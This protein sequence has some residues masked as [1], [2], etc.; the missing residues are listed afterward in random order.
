M[1]LD[2]GVLFLIGLPLGL[3]CCMLHVGFWLRWRDRALLWWASSNGLGVVGALLMLSY[4]RLP[5]E[6][7]RSVAET[8]LFASGLLL[9]LGFRCLAGQSLPLRAFAAATL[10]YLAGFELLQSFVN[11]LAALIMLASFGHG[12]L[13]A[14]VAFD[15]G[16]SQL[17]DRLRVRTALVVVFALHALFY[18]FRSVTAVTVEAGADFLHTVGLQSATLLIGLINVVLWNA[19]AL[20]MAGERHRAPAAPQAK[21]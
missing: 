19:G 3:V 18:L 10:I 5:S 1:K 4:V 6:T 9:W 7:V 2:V 16:R 20:W 11:D 13:H 14:G 21:V 8:A 12:I 17:A 15:L